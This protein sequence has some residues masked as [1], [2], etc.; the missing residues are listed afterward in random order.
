MPGTARHALTPARYY[1]V[2]TEVNVF[3][4]LLNRRPNP[5]NPPVPELW[6]RTIPLAPSGPAA[7]PRTLATPL[8]SVI[9]RDG[10]PGP[11]PSSAKSTAPVSWE[12]F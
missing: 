7:M 4:G 1:I 5:A 8:Y 3:C 10:R 6:K 12:V 9:V 11:P 2:G